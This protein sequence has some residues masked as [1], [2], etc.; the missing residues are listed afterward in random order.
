MVY[1]VWY[2][3]QFQASG[4]SQGTY[5]SRIRKDIIYIYI[6]MCIYIYIYI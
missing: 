5:L 4:K 2:Y 3:L 1:I 6:Y